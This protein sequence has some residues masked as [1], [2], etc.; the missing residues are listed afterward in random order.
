MN[1]GLH[2]NEYWYFFPAIDGFLRLSDGILYF[3]DYAGLEDRKEH[4]KASEAPTMTID[5]EE[6]AWQSISDADKALCKECA[7]ALVHML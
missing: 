4:V 3:K 7:N 5:A 1:F 6:V 2:T